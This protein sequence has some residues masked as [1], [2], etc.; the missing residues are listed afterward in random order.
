M[1]RRPAFRTRRCT[2]ALHALLLLV[3]VSAWAWAG[4]QHVQ[5]TRAAGYN[6][7]EEM[8][9]FRDFARPMAFPSI[10]P[11]L[12][13]GADPA[14]SARHYFESDRL[15]KDF[16]M[17]SIS[18]DESEALRQVRLH[19]DDLGTAPWAVAD[20]MEQM[21]AA[22]QTNDWMLA[23]RCGSTLA[24]YAAD[25]HMPL[26][27]TLN[28]NGQETWQHGLHTRWE[29]DMTKAFFRSPMIRA[30][31]AVYIEDPFQAAIGWSRDSI[32]LVPE[33]LKADIIAKRS[34]GGRTDTEQYYRRLWDL[35]QDM[36]VSRISDSVTDLSSLWYTAWVDAGRP[37]IPPP[38]EE[39]PQQSIHSGVGI[40]PYSDEGISRKPH[41]RKRTF[42]MIIWSVM[43]GIGLIII[44]SS[45]WR[46]IQAQKT[47][48]R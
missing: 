14:E 36:V 2:A 42:D 21:T 17:L 32:A 22:M 11:D 10:Y 1:M 38:Y 5:I 37:A 44:G 45:I 8:S 9:A 47:S 4:A 12:W 7:P 15:N 48:G 41:P 31:P 6:V 27:C 25:L 19:R 29:S 28:F 3:P 23:A 26:H 40:E 20:L 16:D 34:A 24:H 33:L 13:K 43:G 46:G 39:L 18:R 30:Q 35:T